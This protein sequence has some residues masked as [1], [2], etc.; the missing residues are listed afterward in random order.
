MKSQIASS[1]A[2]PELVIGLASLSVVLTKL[3][4]YLI[5]KL[6]Q[7]DKKEK[8]FLSEKERHLFTRLYEM[9]DTHDNNGVPLWYVPREWGVR[10]RSMESMLSEMASNHSKII[11]LL[12]EVLRRSSK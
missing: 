1:F 10:M 12:E 9:H 6:F 5:K 7:H 3:V 4:F 11:F 2:S 8:S